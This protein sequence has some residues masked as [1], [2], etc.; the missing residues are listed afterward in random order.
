MTKNTQDIDA[1]RDGDFEG[2][3]PLIAQDWNRPLTPKEVEAKQKKQSSQSPGT[4]KGAVD[5][6]DYKRGVKDI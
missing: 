4:V 3:K 1:F 5:P 6:T 2:A